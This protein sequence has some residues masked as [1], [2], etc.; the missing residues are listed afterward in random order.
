MNEFDKKTVED[1]IAMIREI[2]RDTIKQ[3]ST[4]TE[5]F[6]NGIVTSVDSE[7]NTATVDI[8]DMVIENIPNKT[9]ETLYI[10]NKEAGTQ[11]SFVRVYT[12]SP[13]MTDAYIGVK[14]N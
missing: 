13:S 4:N 5:S 8:G 14:L 3:M 9:G 6:Y 11:A 1:F 7:K 12:T 10:T 2:V